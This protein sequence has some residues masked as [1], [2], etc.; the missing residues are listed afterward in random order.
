MKYI[1]KNKYFKEGILFRCECGEHEFLEI[2][3]LGDEEGN[4]N[5]LYEVSIS[6]F[7]IGFFEKLKYLFEP[8]QWHKSILINRSDMI[9]LKNFLERKLK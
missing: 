7:T 2:Y 1:T 8:E 9:E 5:D 6:Q 4:D 3:P